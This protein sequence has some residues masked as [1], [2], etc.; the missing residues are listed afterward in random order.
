MGWVTCLTDYTTW[1]QT[2]GGTRGVEVCVCGERVSGG[3][4]GVVK[5]RRGRPSLQLLDAQWSKMVCFARPF[6][7]R[8][9]PILCCFLPLPT[10]QCVRICARTLFSLGVLGSRSPLRRT[11]LLRAMPI[12]AWSAAMSSS[13]TRSRPGERRFRCRQ[14]RELNASNRSRLMVAMVAMGGMDGMGETLWG[15]DGSTKPQVSTWRVLFQR[16]ELNGGRQGV[17]RIGFRG[18]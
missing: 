11:D 17:D 3:H 1:R 6:L 14:G 5:M 8:L 4:A 2:N 7:V 10:E 15:F 12:C 13:I 18:L 9:T 16:R